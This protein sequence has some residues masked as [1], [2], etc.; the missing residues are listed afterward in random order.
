[1]ATAME[2]AAINAAC[3]CMRN[4]VVRDDI[5]YICLTEEKLVD[6]ASEVK[7]VFALSEDVKV[8]LKDEEEKLGKIPTYQVKRWLEQ[9]KTTC[10][11][12]KGLEIEYRGKWFA[13]GYCSI[14]CCS[15]Y[16]IS[17]RADRLSMQLK[18]LKREKNDF[19]DLTET[20]GENIAMKIPMPLDLVETPY[21]NQICTYLN[22]AAVN[23]IGIYGMIGTGK[24]TLLR[25]I[26][27]SLLDDGMKNFNQV[28]MIKDSH[29]LNLEKIQKKIA[30]ELNMPNDSTRNVMRYL[31]GKKFLFL[32]DDICQ[33]VDFAEEVGIPLG[34]NKVIFTVLNR[35]MCSRMRA[36]RI[37]EVKCLKNEKAAWLIFNQNAKIE[38][39]E[40]DSQFNKKKVNDLAK[41]VV[42]KC[43]GLP[44]ALTLFGQAMSNKKT[45]EEWQHVVDKLDKPG[46]SDTLEMENTLHNNLKVCYETLDTPTLK[47]CFLSFSLW[48]NYPTIYKEDVIQCWMGLR[49][50][51]FTKYNE[52][53]NEG[54]YLLGRL[55][56]ACLLTVVGDEVQ[57][58]HMVHRMVHSVASQDGTKM[59]KWIV[60]RNNSGQP[61]VLAEEIEEWKD[62]ERIAVTMD[63]AIKEMPELS[64]NFPNLVSLM[65][66]G[67]CS[68]I[69]LPDGIFQQMKKLEYLDLSSTSIDQLPMGIK[70]ATNLQYLN[71]SKTKIELLPRELAQL[72][73]LKFLICR[74]L[75]LGELEE[76]L[77]SSL[78]K[79]GVLE[80][81]PYTF[82]P[83]KCLRSSAASMKRIGMLV[84]SP[85]VF[86]LISELPTCYIQ[87]EK[88][89]E[90][91]SISFESLSCKN[92]GCLEKLKLTA[93]NELKELVVDGNESNFKKLHL[94]D[95]KNL[96]WIK[97]NGVEPRSYFQKLRKLY[98]AKCKS[99][100]NL[101]W[102]LHLPT[103]VTLKIEQCEILEEFV[104]GKEEE[105]QQ[106]SECYSTFPMLEILSIGFLPSLLSISNDPLIFPCLSNL[107]VEGCPKLSRLP[108]AQHIITS[109]FRR[110]DCEEDWW[111]G[112]TWDDG[113]NI[114]SYIATKINFKEAGSSQPSSSSLPPVMTCPSP[115]IHP[116]DV[117]Q[118]FSELSINKPALALEGLSTTTRA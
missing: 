58:H 90:L 52:A 92:R 31:K 72:K 29:N 33:K 95:L 5:C 61:Q 112:L 69:R 73:E 35:D 26:Y 96:N 23:V 8:K 100:K 71:I 43:E 97:F 7:D 65:L 3:A 82:V 25:V 63:P 66:Q 76:G 59:G 98:I 101:P 116:M 110:L 2:T 99:L 89:H 113:H 14:N 84:K 36:H 11:E 9:S 42:N 60:R 17:R 20:Q 28:I 109:N 30:E 40:F 91:E 21:L 37:V 16:N 13:S 115:C 41:E 87:I 83:I 15:R 22:D 93:C 4:L 50:I 57:L 70:D 12:A 56:N 102:V 80:L 38:D 86:K 67:N 114:K 107:I 32:L 88:L 49:F 104:C 81:Q 85:L 106:A 1:M 78:Y 75:K 46:S 94:W 18:E 64:H 44:L 39:L 34:D 117:I 77:V 108:F 55:Q 105:I 54:C 62:A 53:F 118:S 47:K 6:L 10:N 68:L 48:Y 27:N 74:K 19:K 24:T 45:V 111:N 51:V 79:L 103:L